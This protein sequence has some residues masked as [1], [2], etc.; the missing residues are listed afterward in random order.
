MNPALACAAELPEQDSPDRANLYSH[1]NKIHSQKEPEVY[2]NSTHLEVLRQEQKMRCAAT[3][4][5]HI[6]PGSQR[7]EINP[8]YQEHRMHSQP[9]ID[10]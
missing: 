4:D 8:H 1:A 2:H 10:Y 5:G 9:W 7:S 3:A 6:Q